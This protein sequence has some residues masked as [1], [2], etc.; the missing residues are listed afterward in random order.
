[1]PLAD[2]ITLVADSFPDKSSGL[3]LKN[4]LFGEAR[5]KTLNDRFSECEVLSELSVSEHSGAFD[6]ELLRL[7]HRAKILCINSPE[8]AKQ[9]I[10]KLFRG[11][12]NSLG[13][14]ILAGLLEAMN[15]EIA[16]KITR[17]QPHFLPTLFRAKSEL[18]T[19]AELW[20]AAGDH[21]R[22]LFESLSSI[23]NLTDERI[24]AI[25]EAIIAGGAEMFVRRAM[26]KWGE[27]A[28]FGVLNYVAKSGKP[29][30]ER[31]IGAMTF[32]D[33]TI[34]KWLKE[35]TDRPLFAKIVCVHIV[36]PYSYKI[37][38][39][40]S[41]IWLNTY[42]ELREQGNAVEVNYLA[43]LLLALALQN[44]SPSPTKVI[45][46]CFEHLHQLAWNDK[47][48]DD[49]WIILDPIVPHHLIWLHDWDKCERMRRGLIEAFVKFQWPPEKLHE[50]IKSDDLLVRI[51]KSAKAVQGGHEYFSKFV[52]Q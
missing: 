43:T 46:L 21:V 32:H 45:G 20:R 30:S 11:P 18:G 6:P 47:M 24:T 33:V 34:M 31:V 51:L 2:F 27:P 42:E 49:N 40:G 17:E 48:Q 1:M 15:P 16:K 7:R 35:Q 44:A 41:E 9:L 5:T 39:F 14:E 3:K 23:D 13:E 28:V 29:L 37:K 8:D 10:S 22:E 26:E 36:A 52:R 19:S 12:V 50:C 38:T 4:A 25:S